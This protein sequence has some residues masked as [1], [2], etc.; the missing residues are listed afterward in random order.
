MLERAKWLTI[1]IMIAGM[2]MGAQAAVERI[3]HLPTG[4]VDPTYTPTPAPSSTL[5]PTSTSTPVQ[6]VQAATCLKIAAI[7][8]DPPGNDLAVETVL[9]ENNLDIPVDLAGWTLRDDQK[10]IYIFPVYT[11]ASGQTLSV[12]S[13]TGVDTTG[14]LFWN[15]PS[16]VWNNGGDCAYLRDESGDLQSHACY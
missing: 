12:W 4:L 13:R 11:L 10:N 15:L 16:E 9:I 5:D 8:N 7:V 6:T 1:M 3:F 14:N 2:V